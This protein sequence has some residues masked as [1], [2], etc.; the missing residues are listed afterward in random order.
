MLW[1]AAFFF[2]SKYKPTF[3]MYFKT[4]LKNQ[5]SYCLRKTGPTPTPA[6]L[7]QFTC[8]AAAHSK[9]FTGLS[10]AVNYLRPHVFRK[11][12]TC[13]LL[14]TVLFRHQLLR[15]GLDVIIMLVKNIQRKCFFFKKVLTEILKS[16]TQFFLIHMDILTRQI[17]IIAKK[18]K[19]KS[20]RHMVN[21]AHTHQKKK[22]HTKL[23][24]R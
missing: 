3:R 15:T 23:I 10:G 19:S 22:K 5:T 9:T 18:P 8:L 13:Q 16:I 17:N 1:I 11:T 2:F 6:D 14:S 21:K 7:R 20:N 24:Q 4:F 12:S